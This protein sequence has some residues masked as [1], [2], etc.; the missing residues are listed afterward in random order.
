M[1][2]TD[3]NNKIIAEFM[4]LNIGAY[5]TY[6]EESPTQYTVNDLEYHKSWDWLIPVANKFSD[7]ILI[8]N[9]D[10]TYNLVIE[11]IKEYNQNK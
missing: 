9:I 7:E 2:N 1:N 11:Y 5:T 10:V 8:F 4:G 3:E 6:P